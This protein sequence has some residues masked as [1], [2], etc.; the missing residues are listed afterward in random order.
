MQ[1]LRA[2][3]RHLRISEEYQNAERQFG[4][5]GVLAISLTNGEV[6]SFTS[7]WRL[8][9]YALCIMNYALSTVTK[10]L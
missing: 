6:L 10:A 8:L 2:S 1:M 3:S 7:Q 4:A 9:N 5:I